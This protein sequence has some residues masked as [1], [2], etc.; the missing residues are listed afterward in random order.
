[1]V[2]LHAS[3]VINMI[4][5]HRILSAKVAMI[6][7][8]SVPVE[9]GERLGQAG[10]GKGPW[11][12]V[13]QVGYLPDD[14][15][16]ALLSGDHPLQGEFHVG[17]VSATIGPDQGAWGPFA[18]NYRL[19][20]SS[21]KKSGRYRIRYGDVESPSF[22]IGLDAYAAVP[23]A[24]IGFMKLQ[25]C[26]TNPVTGKT[27]HQQDGN[28]TMTGQRVDLVGGWHDAA[29]RLKHMITTSYCVAALALARGEA[30]REEARY[31]AGLV[32]KLHRAPDL[33]Y[34]QIGD[35]R[36][37]R[38]PET[39]WHDDQS[40]Y[41]WG[42][43][44]PRSAWRAT[45]RPEGPKYKNKS[46]G[47]ASLAG[48]CS[49]AL[50]LTGDVAA[51]RSLYR[52]A[53]A[54]PG[55]AMSIPVLAPYYYGEST[56][57]DDLEWAAVEL[58]RATREPSFLEQAVT[59]ADQAGDNPWMGKDRHGHYEFFPY[60]NL[61]HW[62][63]HP[64][65]DPEVQGRL[66]GYYRSGLERIRERAERNPYRIGTPL[67][68]CSTNDVIAFATQARLYEMM[69]GDTRFRA[70]AAEARDWILGRNPWGVSFVLGV[71]RDGVAASRPHHLFY[72]LA[73]QLPV[74]GLVDGPVMRSINES[75]KYSTF[76]PDPLARFQ[77]DVAVYHDEFA[78]FS[79]N[80]PI[81]DGTV[82][83]LLL[84]DLWDRPE[85]LSR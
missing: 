32:R 33:L 1:M 6:V 28:D 52:L 73:H 29:D 24:L 38:P 74:G 75:L 23:D 20:F 36:D 41:G 22:A 42:P 72:K 8:L 67:V 26:G 18:H 63:L 40:D 61:A 10:S 70:L 7:A 79:T 25:R 85:G 54:H 43:G 82:S 59:Y 37:H 21:L 53:Q 57:L 9:G 58:F 34:I 46:T 71:P 11:I 80:E 2:N 12:R 44:G 49:A 65:I 13:N 39:L 14:P 35:D 76:G 27:C 68:W 30:A 45:G 77:S 16:I 81:I 48:R 56:Y 78:D 55:A 60:V 51:A 66:A 84:L 19:D 5:R 69:T 62:R 47:L 4:T 3:Q 31:G 17:E 50:A 64:L 15:K 83:L